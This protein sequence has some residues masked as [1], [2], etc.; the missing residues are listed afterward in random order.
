MSDAC[1]DSRLAK[2]Y[3]LNL[4]YKKRFHEM[5]STYKTTQEGKM[6]LNKMQSLE[7]RIRIIFGLYHV[8]TSTQARA[9]VLS[10]T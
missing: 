3:D 5:F 2:K 4:V 1:R 8:S 6:L 10:M 9:K 7:V